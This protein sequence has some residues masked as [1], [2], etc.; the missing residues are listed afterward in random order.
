M[1]VISPPRPTPA[2]RQ[3]ASRPLQLT[4]SVLQP[5]HTPRGFRLTSCPS[6][7]ACP[8]VTSAL[9]TDVLSTMEQPHPEL[10]RGMRVAV[11]LP[12]PDSVPSLSCHLS[13][14]SPPP[15]ESHVSRRLSGHPK[16]P[17]APLVPVHGPLAPML[18]SPCISVING[19][20][21]CHPR[22]YDKCHSGRCSASCS[23]SG[24]VTPGM[25]EFLSWLGFGP[26]AE[27]ALSFHA[28]A[29]S[30]PPTCPV[31]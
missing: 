24:F 4:L 23:F 19:S 29:T 13:S 11:P 14:S 26:M 18:T 7:W 25:T 12:T 5:R 31:S 21:V 9:S 22:V 6:A 8:S 16:H 20:F 3:S 10:L 28:A 30:R 27:S 1:N 2:R 17:F 15:L